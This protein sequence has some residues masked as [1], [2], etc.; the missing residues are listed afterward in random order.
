MDLITRA[1][2]P[3]SLHK[4]VISRCLRTEIQCLESLLKTLEQS[5]WPKDDYIQESLKFSCSNL[6]DLTRYLSN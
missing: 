2:R 3:S 5:E 6:K 4:D 1:D